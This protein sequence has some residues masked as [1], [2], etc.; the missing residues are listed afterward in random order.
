MGQIVTWS[1]VD[2]TMYTESMLKLFKEYIKENPEIMQIKSALNARGCLL[3]NGHNNYYLRVNQP[4]GTFKDYDLLHCDLEV[5]VVDND[6]VFYET[7]DSWVL[8]HSP[9]TLGHTQ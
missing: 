2:E 3:Y 6:A 5:V 8:D 4:D 9:L 7:E 1:I